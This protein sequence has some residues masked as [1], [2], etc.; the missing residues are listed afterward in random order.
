MSAQNRL[1]DDERRAQWWHP[2][3]TTTDLDSTAAPYRR[4]ALLPSSAQAE[5]RARV[6]ARVAALAGRLVQ[7][8]EVLYAVASRVA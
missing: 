1:S 4:L 5:C 7:R 2:T 8:I 3:A 6:A